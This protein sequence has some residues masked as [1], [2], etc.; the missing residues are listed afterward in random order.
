MKLADVRKLSIRKNLKIRFALANGLEC[1]VTEHGVAQV[2][3]LRGVPDFNLEQ[4][5]ASAST[6]ILEPV[7]TDKKH[8]V[9]PRPVGREELTALTTAGPSAAAHEEEE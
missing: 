5:F 2:A 9:Q 3:G 6:F 1:I 4:E 7:K 8:P